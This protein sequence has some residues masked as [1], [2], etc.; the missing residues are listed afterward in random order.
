MSVP[1]ERL[2]SRRTPLC[3]RRESGSLCNLPNPPVDP[4][5]TSCVAV[6]Q[7][8][9]VLVCARVPGG[10][11]LGERWLL[12][13]RGVMIDLNLDQG[14]ATLTEWGQAIVSLESVSVGQEDSQ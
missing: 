13:E 2:A 5:A 4:A 12:M 7:E 8:E 1:V 3:G 11:L 9:N 10:A 14:L 6:P